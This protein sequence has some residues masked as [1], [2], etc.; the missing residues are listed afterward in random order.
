MIVSVKKFNKNFRGQIWEA[1]VAWKAKFQ[2]W[3]LGKEKEGKNGEPRTSRA[4]I[5][6]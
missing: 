1:I 2:R 4:N 3:K 6:K 5:L